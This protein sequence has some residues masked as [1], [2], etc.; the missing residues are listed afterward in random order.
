MST[1]KKET[2]LPGGVIQAD[3]DAWKKKHGSVH[4][5]AAQDKGKSYFFYL[6]EPTDEVMSLAYSKAKES[7]W[8][9][10][11]VLFSNCWLGGDEAVRAKQ[12]I[13]SGA[14]HQTAAYFIGDTPDFKAVEL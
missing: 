5:F 2:K 1:S 7:S 12:R 3:V 11:L 4:Q 14:V 10:G 8:E 9:A 13:R 6:S